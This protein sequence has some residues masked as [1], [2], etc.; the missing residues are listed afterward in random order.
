MRAALLAIAL[1]FFAGG[2]ARR[3]LRPEAFFAGLDPHATAPARGVVA[4][5]APGPAWVRVEGA[6]FKMGTTPLEL[7]DVLHQCRGEILG[8]HCNDREMVGFAGLFGSF[9]AEL[10]AHD[11]AISPFEIERTEVSVDAY[12]RCVAAA[13]CAPAG[14]PGLD[15]RFDRPE[16]PVTYVSWDDA[17]AYCAF[18]HARLP[19]EA[20]WELAARG[21]KRR[22][23]PWGAVYN[24]HLTNH[25]AFA[26]DASDATDGYVG[27][28]PVE[29]FADG[30][31]PEGIVNL[32]GNVAEW[33]SDYLEI[34]DEGFGYAPPPTKED[35]GPLKNPRGPSSGLGHVVRGG[36]YLQGAAWQRGA[37]RAT[38]ILPRAPTVGF[39]CA[40]DAGA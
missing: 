19:T 8:L 14:Y 11:V 18:L 9:R 27:L 35:A 30:A 37:A 17:T 2:D 22:P 39:R 20:E 7:I 5:R 34:D 25:G 23:Y 1:G 36:S 33:V 15:A 10:P 32:A 29:S 21:P 26:L 13:R 38:L 24:P 12:T 28:A 40:R 31:T 4:L 6:T 16:L 3:P